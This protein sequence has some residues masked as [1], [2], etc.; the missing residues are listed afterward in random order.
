VPATAARR[1]DHD[2]HSASYEADCDDAGFVIV[3]S[4]ILLLE[5]ST[6]E[7]FFGIIEIDPAFAQRPVMLAG[8]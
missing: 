5:D 4:I 7:H 1:P 8:S 3:A 2:Y 6:S